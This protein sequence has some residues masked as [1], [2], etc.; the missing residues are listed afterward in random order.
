MYNVLEYRAKIFVIWGAK[1]LFDFI[2]L[3][4]EIFKYEYFGLIFW[5]EMWIF[6]VENRVRGRLKE[7]GLG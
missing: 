3:R 7:G 2:R 5:V 6:W 1:C 4:L